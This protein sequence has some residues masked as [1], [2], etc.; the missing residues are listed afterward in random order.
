M[1]RIEPKGFIGFIACLIWMILFFS[2]LP[3]CL[4]YISIKDYFI[5]RKNKKMFAK[6]RKYRKNNA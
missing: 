5:N 2:I 4:I 6:Q 1:A 3:F